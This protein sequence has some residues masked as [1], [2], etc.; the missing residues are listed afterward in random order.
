[1]DGWMN[2]EDTLIGI[3]CANVHIHAQR[4]YNDAYIGN[5]PY[6]YECASTM[7]KCTYRPIEMVIVST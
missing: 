3:R 5:G 6:L 2:V 1:M 4:S 7:L